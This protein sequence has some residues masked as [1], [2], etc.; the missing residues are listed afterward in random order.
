MLAAVW[1]S[2]GNALKAGLIAALVWSCG[3][4]AVLWFFSK[5]TIPYW[6]FIRVLLPYSLAFFG[7]AALIFEALTRWIEAG[8]RTFGTE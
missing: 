6:N 8:P 2:L 4:G 5:P 1:K 7:A 3:F